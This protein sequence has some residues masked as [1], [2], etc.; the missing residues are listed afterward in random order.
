[1]SEHSN[2]SPSSL[3]RR[4]ACLGSANAENGLPDSTSEVAAEGTCAHWVREQCLTTKQDVD[5]FVGQEVSADGFTFTVTRDWANLLQ[6]GIDRARELA[7]DL[8]NMHVEARVRLDAWMPGEGGTLD[9]GIEVRD[10]K[11]EVVAVHVIDLKFGRDPVT[12]KR[13]P[14]LMAYALGLL[15]KLGLLDRTDL[16]VVLEIDQP[17]AP[18]R[19][20]QWETTVGEIVRFGE[21][22]AAAFIAG[23]DPAAP[24]TPTP[25]GCKYCKA[26]DHCAELGGFIIDLFDLANPGGVPM[27]PESERL[28]VENLALLLTNAKLVSKALAKYE[29]RGRAELE[30]GKLSSAQLGVKLVAGSGK[31]VWRDEKEA[32]QF[33]TSKLPRK[34]DAFNQKLISPAEA[35]NILGTRNWAKAQDLIEKSEGRPMLVPLS[36]KRPELVPVVNLLDELPD[37]GLDELLDDLIGDDPVATEATAVEDDDLI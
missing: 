23:K 3:H 17:R 33:L 22:L 1:M 18:G 9:T 37:E 28:S 32:E 27:I 35:E 5:A 12:A 19:G 26:A 24:R 34:T 2:W 13:N 11:G 4:L 29:D 31:R 21:T 7:G 25:E 20:D 30:E 10:K 16:K 14:Q 8:K 6:P 15:A 36:D